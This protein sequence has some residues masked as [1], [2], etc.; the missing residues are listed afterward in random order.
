MKITILTLFP[1]MVRPFFENSIMKRA[2]EKGIVEYS[3][4]NFRDFAEGVHQK[5]D[6]IP[7]GGGA[8]MVI[9]PEPLTK[10]LDSVGAK[11]KRVIFPTPSGK[12]FNQEYAK[13]LSKDVQ[14]L[15]SQ[16]HFRRVFHFQRRA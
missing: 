4:I 10:A 1:E 15:K 13:S 9:M 5:A 6:D 8:G 11:D 12:V 3:I 16:P 7:F 2:V 14:G